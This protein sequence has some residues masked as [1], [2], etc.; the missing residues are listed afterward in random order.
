MTNT[1]ATVP[2]KSPHS[3]TAGS[4]TGLQLLW[5]VPAGDVGRCSGD[6]RR[7]GWEGHGWVYR[8]GFGSILKMRGLRSR[9]G[10]ET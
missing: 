1:K 3:Q 10:T 6:G 9:K 5:S 7:C 8:L 4:E 2:Q